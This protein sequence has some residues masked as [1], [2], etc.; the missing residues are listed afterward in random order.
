MSLQFSVLASGSSGN[1]IYVATEKIKLL[2]EKKNTI[3]F[4]TSGIDFVKRYANE[5]VYNNMIMKKSKGLGKAAKRVKMDIIGKFTLNK[6]NDNEYPQV[7]IVDFRVE[8]DNDI[9][10]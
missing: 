3:K 2:G 6:W 7:E 10:F 9:L 1:A 4:E 5:E 8:E